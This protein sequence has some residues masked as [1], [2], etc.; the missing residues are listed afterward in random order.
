MTAIGK[1]DGY[2]PPSHVFV[3]RSPGLRDRAV[4]RLR[5]RHLDLALATGAP[6]EATAVLALRAR[7]LTA[8]GTRRSIADTYRR[9]VREAREGAT[10]G[11]ARLIPSTG[12][13]IAASDELTGLA[14]K[15]ST[16]GPVDAQG[17]AEALLL[18]SDGTGPLYN[19]R[20]QATLRASAAR[21]AQDLAL[22]AP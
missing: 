20:S 11:R 16:P 22:R 10:G 21:A 12:R 9:L 5:A 19:S 17:V 2:A 6:P 15:L 3:A 1:S 18:L 14:D 7:R 4:A 8:L 13:V